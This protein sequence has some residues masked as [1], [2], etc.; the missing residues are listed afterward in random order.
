[1]SLNSN[2]SQNIP[3]LFLE[4]MRHDA[5]EPSI[6]TPLVSGVLPFGPW[7]RWKRKHDVWKTRQRELIAAAEKALR[8]N[9]DKGNLG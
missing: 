8:W 3:E 7:V 9:T 6:P 2:G 1:M 5:L 4:I